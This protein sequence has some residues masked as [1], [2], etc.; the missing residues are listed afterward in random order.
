MATTTKGI[1]YPTS[2][3]S[4]APLETHFS[5]LA[6]S[7]NTV[8]TRASGE[9]QF[10]GPAATGGIQSVSVSF[11]TA[12][13]TAPKVTATIQTTDALSAYAVN[14]VG[15]PTTTGFTAIAY[16]LNGSGANSGLKL[17]WHAFE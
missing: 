13:T 3:D 4:I 14:I 2:S 6:G 1:V 10:T 12:F 16:R 11:P 15:S 8:L 17:V 5:A 9:L 7:V